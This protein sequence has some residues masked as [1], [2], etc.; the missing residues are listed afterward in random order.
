[1][2]TIA[3]TET[4]AFSDGRNYAQMDRPY[5]RWLAA[6]SNQNVV[7]IRPIGD[8]FFRASDDIVR[9]LIER[10]GTSPIRNPR[11]RWVGKPGKSLAS[12]NYPTEKSGT[13]LLTATTFA[14]GDFGSSGWTAI[15]GAVSSTPADDVLPFGLSNSVIIDGTKKV[16]QDFSMSV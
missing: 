3:F 1:P 11:L 8:G 6:T 4:I 13:E 15:G 7:R 10:P 9:V 5:S 12:P 2:N 16:T 14:P